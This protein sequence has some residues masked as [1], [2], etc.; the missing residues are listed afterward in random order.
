MNAVTRC[1][2]PVLLLVATV[3]A[4]QDFRDCT[5]MYV[6]A[7]HARIAPKK[8]SGLPWD[9][10]SS[11]DPK[12]LVKPAARTDLSWSTLGYKVQDAAGDVHWNPAQ[13]SEAKGTWLPLRTGDA[14]AVS[15]L[16]ADMMADDKILGLTVTVP[17]ALPESGAWFSTLE[18]DGSAVTLVVSAY[19]GTRMCKGVQGS[20]R[21]VK[22]P[23]GVEAVVG[24]AQFNE[25]F[26]DM[27]CAVAQKA[28]VCARE[29]HVA[30]YADVNGDGITDISSV[31]LVPHNRADGMD[32][33]IYYGAWLGKADG[34]ARKV[35]I[36]ACTSLESGVLKDGV[37]CI[38]HEGAGVVF[39]HARG[40]SRAAT[41]AD[42]KRLEDAGMAEFKRLRA[43]EDNRGTDDRTLCKEDE[44]VETDCDVK[45]G[46]LASLCS[47]GDVL[48]YRFGTK[49]KVELEWPKAPTPAKV[50]FKWADAGMDPERASA[51]EVARTLS[52]QNGDFTYELS[53]HQ[54]R[55]N[56]SRTLSVTRSGKRILEEACGGMSL[57]G[58]G[59]LFQ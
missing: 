1:T 34:T 18:T 59:R 39:N 19:D 5:E 35:F 23:D 54:Y 24:V 13:P 26:A 12:L 45:G 6:Y 40:T 57:A 56:D 49:A 14:L 53:E 7:V 8:P 3:A 25:L 47:K 37:L 29:K 41:D 55:M 31:S 43:M 22:V 48:Y 42:F 15:L 30:K 32:R 10:G 9:E 16:D 44:K 4:A 27:R 11:A 46:K 58:M 36:G 17:R 51:G 50:N 52:F 20:P 21:W 38:Q 33:A 2:I 28:P